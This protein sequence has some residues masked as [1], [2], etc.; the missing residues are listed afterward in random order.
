MFDVTNLRVVQPH[1]VAPGTLLLS[2]AHYSDPPTFVFAAG[3]QVFWFE[4]GGNK[5]F[6]G[7]QMANN[8]HPFVVA[9]A[10]RLLV[11]L[12]NTISPTRS[13]IP[14]GS[15][16]LIGDR[17]CFAIKINHGTAYVGVDGQIVDD[18]RSYDRLVA[19]PAWRLDVLADGDD[20]WRTVVKAPAVEQ[21][22]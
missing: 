6:N 10:P 11:D 21:T 1:E 9:G 4:F 3:D 12:E 8:L 17:P 19:F 20:D 22:K 2:G 7:Y 15:A 5:P 16:V 14:I 18:P 13:D